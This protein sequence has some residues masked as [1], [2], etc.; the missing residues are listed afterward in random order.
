MPHRLAYLLPGL[1]CVT[2]S[3]LACREFAS[4]MPRT[5]VKSARSQQC[6]GVALLDHL[7]PGACTHRRTATYHRNRTLEQ[8]TSVII[9]VFVLLQRVTLHLHPNI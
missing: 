9:Q 7:G 5:T 3:P 1:D 6:R 4:W 8:R 2:S